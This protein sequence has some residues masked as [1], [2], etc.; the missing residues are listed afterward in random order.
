MGF[1]IFEKKSLA[2]YV[3]QIGC[4]RRFSSDTEWY[5]V[6]NTSWGNQKVLYTKLKYYDL[7]LLGN[8]TLSELFWASNKYSLAVFMETRIAMLCLVWKGKTLKTGR[9]LKVFVSD[10]GAGSIKD[11]GGFLAEWLKEYL[12]Y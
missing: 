7:I 4:K 6:G 8:K 10:D 11:N 5:Y 1:F 3:R 9:F 12:S 2:S